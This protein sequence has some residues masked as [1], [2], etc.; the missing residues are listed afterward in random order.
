MSTLNNK[1]ECEMTEDTQDFETTQEE[2]EQPQRKRE[3]DH[4]VFV[5]AKPFNRV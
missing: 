1:G 4:T 2:F 5:G 3:D